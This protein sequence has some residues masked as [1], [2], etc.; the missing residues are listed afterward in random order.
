MQFGGGGV[1]ASRATAVTHVRDATAWVEARL[2]P[3]LGTPTERATVDVCRRSTQI[4]ND[5][6]WCD[7]TGY[8]LYPLEGLWTVPDASVFAALLNDGSTSPGHPCD[9]PWDGSSIVCLERNGKVSLKVNPFA[10]E[11]G[12]SKIPDYPGL[13]ISERVEWNGFDRLEAATKGRPCV[14][15]AFTD[16]YFTG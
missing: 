13:P 4:F 7:R 5:T 15:V 16:H 8:L 9:E 2:A 11:P 10:Q 6:R 12:D 14:V 1:D 3:R